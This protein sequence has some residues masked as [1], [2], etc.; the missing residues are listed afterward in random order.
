VAREPSICEIQQPR[1]CGG[2]AEAVVAFREVVRVRDRDE[3]PLDGD[4]PRQQLCEQP[5]RRPSLIMY[6]RSLGIPGQRVAQQRDLVGER[7]PARQSGLLRDHGPR[8]R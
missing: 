7:T 4:K 8:R 2:K 5:L 1:Q 6:G 3:V